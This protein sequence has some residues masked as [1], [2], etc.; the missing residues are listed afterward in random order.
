[1]FDNFLHTYMTFDSK[2]VT[3]ER[4]GGDQSWKKHINF[5]V[6][7]WE[8]NTIFLGARSVENLYVINQEGLKFLKKVI[9]RDSMNRTDSTE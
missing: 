7:S 3:T 5:L 8:S 4:L 2:H 1:M 9:F 6:P